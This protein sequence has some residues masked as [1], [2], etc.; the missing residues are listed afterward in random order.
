MSPRAA[1]KRL[2][3]F[4]IDGT[5]IT[6]SGASREAFDAALRQVYGFDGDLARFDFSG[7]TDPQI[8]YM[9]LRAS[10][11]DD[12]TIAAGLFSFW[13]HYLSGLARNATVARVRVLPGILALLEALVAHENVVLALLTG[14]LENGARLKLA[15][16]QLNQ[17][18]PFGA[19][20]SDSANREELPPVAVQ[21]AAERDGHRFSGRDVVILGDTIFDVRCGVPHGATT[22]AIASGRTPID[23]LRAENPT[24][25]FTSAEDTTALLNAIIS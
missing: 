4:D 13:E 21:R 17:Y 8:A 7:R 25:A 3:L 6:D 15:P 23:T 24:H 10:G 18:F 2:V 14:N 19:F 11:F 12:P 9:V 20:G 1:S 16:P 22:I 5:L